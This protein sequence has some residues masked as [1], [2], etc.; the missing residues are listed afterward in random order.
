MLILLQYTISLAFIVA[1]TLIYKQYRYSVSFDLGYNT[2]NIINLRLFGNDPAPLI[3]ELKQFPQVKNLSQSSTVTSVGSYWF[4][5][6]K[7]RN[8]DSASVSYNEVDENYLPIHGHKF[9]AGSN[10][11]RGSENDSAVSNQI[12]VN[13]ALLKRFEIGTPEQAIGEE[14]LV[15]GEKRIIHG[16]L[17]DF[18][19]GR[20]DNEIGP[21]T[22]LYGHSQSGY[23][24]LS[25]STN[26]IFSSMN[27]IEAA[28]KEFDPVHPAEALFYDDQIKKAYEEEASMVTIMSFMAFIAISIASMGLLGMVVFTTESRQKE[29]SICKVFGAT[30]LNLIYKL[31]KGFI[32]LLLLAAIIAIPLTYYYVNTVI[33]EEIVYKTSFGFFDIMLGVLIVMAIALLTI[34]FETFRAARSNPATV[35]RNE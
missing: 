25:V 2:E 32:L 33:F 23:L 19:Y 22:F 15:S 1:V 21:F 26:D 13:E 4:N 5:T 8:L 11:I 27:K 35:L 20:L 7:Y 14:I 18:Q 29:I 34:C 31:G 17:K 24:N 12:I 9:L 6:I 3:N 28:W 16:V 30:E 10:F